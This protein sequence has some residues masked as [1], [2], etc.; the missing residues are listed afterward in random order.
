MVANRLSNLA[1]MICAG[2]S[3]FDLSAILIQSARRDLNSEPASVSGFTL[4]RDFALVSLFAYY[5][6]ANAGGVEYEEAFS[7]MRGA[8]RN[9]YNDV[10]TA[11]GLNL[12][13]L[14]MSSSFPGMQ[15][16]RLL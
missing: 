11:R 9:I 8:R 7:T 14:R 2:R 13:P 10:G 6:D 15:P 12:P 3:P 5:Y 4:S 1:G 16:A